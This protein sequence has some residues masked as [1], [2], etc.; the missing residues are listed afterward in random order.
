MPAPMLAI[1][2]VAALGPSFLN[3]LLAVTVVWWPLY[4]RVV[5]GEIR[6][7]ASRPHFEAAKL[8]GVSTTRIWFRHLLPGAL[9]SVVIVAS[10]DVGA[11]ILVLAS[12]SFLGL[13]SADPATELGTMTASGLPYLL[14]SPGMCLFPALAVFVIAFVSNVAGDAV[15]KLVTRD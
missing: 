4:A 15:G 7:L 11:L 12:L 14:S 1:A 3:A 10:L 8:A 9:S 6:A 13:G 5:R 2:V